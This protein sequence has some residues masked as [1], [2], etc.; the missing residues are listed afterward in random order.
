MGHS[1]GSGLPPQ[2][3]LHNPRSLGVPN[4]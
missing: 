1:K 3:P 4:Q 2:P